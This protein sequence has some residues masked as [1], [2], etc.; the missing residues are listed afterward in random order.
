MNQIQPIQRLR[1]QAKCFIELGFRKLAG[2]ELAWRELAG[3]LAMLSRT[4]TACA[5]RVPSLIPALAERRKPSGVT[6][7]EGSRPAATIELRNLIRGCS[8][9]TVWTVA[10]I[11]FLPATVSAQD[12]LTVA[13]RNNERSASD[14]AA[15]NQSA[16]TQLTGTVAATE[17]SSN[18]LEIIIKPLENQL[19]A[20][21]VTA[22]SASHDGKY[23][24]I[25][26]DDHVIRLFDVAMQKTVRELAGH[27]DWIQSLVFSADS[28]SL[29]SGGND[30]RVLRWEHAYPVA[31]AE[32]VKLSFAIRSL[33]L[34][35][36]RQLLAVG[37]FSEEIKVW[38]L[39]HGTW[40][41][42]FKCDCGDQRCVRF[43]PNGNRLLCGGRDGGIRVWDVESG[44]LI[45]DKHLHRSKVFTAAFS[46]EGDM[47]TSA[48]EDRHLIRYDLTTDQVKLDREIATTK[49]MSM[50]LVNDQLVAVAGSDNSIR[51]YDMLA[52]GVI[53]NLHG[54][55]GTVAVMCPCGDLLASGSFD[56]TVRIWDLEAEVGQQSKLAMPV[57]LAPLDVDAR[58]RIR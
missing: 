11:G 37:G 56:T 32:I 51:L 19:S 23:L 21:V 50:C 42:Q 48:G 28:K 29:Y 20:P 2:R 24:A 26:G 16:T 44:E 52:D 1:T 43:S 39:A 46:S 30:G 49:L 34:A 8:L 47:I 15:A 4:A 5:A 22:M 10:G 33:S 58:M 36:E 7:P 25:A 9:A 3:I 17:A 57:G 45:L 18:S 12:N 14:R 38:D 27:T 35:S 13:V 6:G 53:A 40:K 54:H 41:H 31:P 55:F